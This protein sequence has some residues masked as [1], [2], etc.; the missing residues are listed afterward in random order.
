MATEVWQKPCESADVKLM[1]MARLFLGDE[2]GQTYGDGVLEPF[3]A[4]A[5][6]MHGAIESP[7]LAGLVALYAA[8]ATNQHSLA[9]LLLRAMAAGLM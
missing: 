5:R 3:L 9:D 2:D 7:R 1:Q 4:H 8:M 6:A